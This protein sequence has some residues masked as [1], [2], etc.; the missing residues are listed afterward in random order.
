M[1]K[2]SAGLLT[3]TE[4]RAPQQSVVRWMRWISLVDDDGKYVACD[5]G[6]NVVVFTFLGL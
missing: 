5:P 1:G 3:R 6:D 4:W 2:G